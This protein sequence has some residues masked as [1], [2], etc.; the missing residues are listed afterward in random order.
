MS[1]AR[2]KAIA[3]ARRRPD[4]MP[5]LPWFLLLLGLLA[6]TAAF[7]QTPAAPQTGPST[8]PGAGTTLA[9]PRAP[10]TPGGTTQNGVAVPVPNRDPG[11]ARTVPAPATSMPVIPPPGS[12][13]GNPNVVPK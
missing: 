7:A 10:D 1:R 11:M 9:T 5:W 4:P 12:P 13:G 2:A 6:T 8:T 3:I